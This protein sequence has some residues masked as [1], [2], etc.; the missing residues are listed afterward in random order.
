MLQTVTEDERQKSIRR[1]GAEFL[2]TLTEVTG[3]RAFYPDP[4]KDLITSAELLAGYLRSQYVIG[5]SL[6]LEAKKGSMRK[7]RVKL[8]NAPGREKYSVTSPT[9]HAQPSK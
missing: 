8:V 1:K 3:G 5:Y 4:G 9:R 7:V 2:N 6:P